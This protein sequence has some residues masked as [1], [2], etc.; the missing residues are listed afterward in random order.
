MDIAVSSGPSAHETITGPSFSA[1]LATLRGIKVDSVPHSF[2]LPATPARREQQ[3][4]GVT[5]KRGPI[6]TLGKPVQRVP[7]EPFRTFGLGYE[8]ETPVLRDLPECDSMRPATGRMEGAKIPDVD[9]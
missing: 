4:G 1:Y 6:H 8:Y 3:P 2:G 5:G 7:L 9:G